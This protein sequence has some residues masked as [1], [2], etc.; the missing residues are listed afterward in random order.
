MQYMYSNTR[1]ST[2][3]GQQALTEQTDIILMFRLL[4]TSIL[5]VI[6]QNIITTM[7]LS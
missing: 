3:P 5:E 1:A 7:P 6:N 2:A 4:N